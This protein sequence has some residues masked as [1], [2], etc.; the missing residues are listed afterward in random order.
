MIDYKIRITTPERDS[1][2]YNL[3]DNPYDNMFENNGSESCYIYGRWYEILG[4]KPKTGFWENID[5]ETTVLEP[6]IGSIMVW[7]GL[8]N[9]KNQYGIVERIF[10]D[11]TIVISRS[12]YHNTL[13]EIVVVR[14]SNNYSLGYGYTFK[15]FIHLPEID[16]EAV[17]PEEPTPVVEEKPKKKKV[18][19]KIKE[20][21]T[22]KKT[23]TTKKKASK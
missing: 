2:F 13:F 9:L 7:E 22:T 15:G 5:K 19:T 20:K 4:N 16:N 17:K 14:K 10:D 3:P 21:V 8:G 23:T 11:G 12:M 6:E 18:V 1:K